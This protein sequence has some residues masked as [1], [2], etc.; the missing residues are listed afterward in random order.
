M[1][2]SEDSHRGKLRL[3]LKSLTR[4]ILKQVSNPQLSVTQ[5]VEHLAIFEGIAQQVGEGIIVEVGGKEVEQRLSQVINAVKAGTPERYVLYKFI[6]RVK[7]AG[8]DGLV[9]TLANAKEAKGLIKSASINVQENVRENFVLKHYA[10]LNI[11]E[12]EKTAASIMDL[13]NTGDEKK[14]DH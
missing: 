8:T 14:I 13:S 9:K 5:V 2:F 12:L 7:V 3:L 11:K 6:A 4:H 1:E 10:D